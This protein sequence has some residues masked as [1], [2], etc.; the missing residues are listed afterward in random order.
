MAFRFFRDD[1]APHANGSR[2]PFPRTVL[3][4]SKTS[5]VPRTGRSFTVKLLPSFLEIANYYSRRSYNGFGW[6]A[7][8]SRST[9]TLLLSTTTVPVSTQLGIAGAGAVRQSLNS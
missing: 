8:A 4:S 2:L 6:A 9:F 5:E 3:N 7:S 1:T